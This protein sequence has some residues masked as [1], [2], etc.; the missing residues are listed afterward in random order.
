MILSKSSDC[1]RIIPKVD[2]ASNKDDRSSRAK[3]SN[4]RDPLQLSDSAFDT[5]IWRLEHGGKG[6][7]QHRELCYGKIFR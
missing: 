2:L 6:A 7:D 1:P 4:F 3:M 5:G